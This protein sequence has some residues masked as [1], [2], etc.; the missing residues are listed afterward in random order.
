[1]QGTVLKSNVTLPASLQMPA[2]HVVRS[3][4][5]IRLSLLVAGVIAN[6]LVGMTQPLRAQLVAVQSAA[7]TQNRSDADAVAKRPNVVLIT[8]DDQP[9]SVLGCYGDPLA[10]T[11]NI[12]H[13]AAKGTRFTQSTVSHSICWVSRTS[14]LSGRYG[15][16]YSSPADPDALLP[17]YL[18]TMYPQ[19]LRD[20]GYRTGHFGK[21]GPRLPAGFQPQSLFDAFDPIGRDPFFHP[22]PDGSLRHETDLIVD[23]GIAFVSD[24]DS[25]A[26]FMLHLSFNACHGEDGDRRPGVGFYPWPQSADDL[27]VDT[28]FPPPMRNAQEHFDSLPD[29]IATAINRERFFWAW[30][31]P[32]KYQT[33]LRAYYRMTSGIDHALGRFLQSLEQ[34][35]ILENTILVYTSDNGDALGSRGLQGKWSHFDES[36]VVPLIIV[37]PRVA[38]ANRGQ[39]ADAQVVNVDLPSTILEWAGV[40]IPNSY[41]GRSLVPLVNSA[42]TPADWRTD[43]FHEHY[44]VRTRL[45]AFEGVR[46]DRYK[47]ARYV[48]HGNYEFLHDRHSDPL[49]LINL[50]ADPAYADVR[51]RLSDL[52]D[53]RVAELGGELRPL[54][55]AFQASSPRHPAIA[56]NVSAQQDDD[57]YTRMF[58]GKTLNQ[59]AGDSRYWSVQDGAITGKTDGSLDK[60]RFLTWTHSTVQ[61]FDLQMQ[62]RITPGGNSGIQYRGLSR[63]DIDLDIV[64]GYQCDIVADVPQYNGMLYEERGRRILAHTGEKVVIDP[65]GQPWIVDRLATDG[66]PSVTEAAGQWHDYRVLVRGNHHQH[67]INGHLTVDVIDLDAAGR[68]LEGVVAMQVHVGPAMTVQFRDLKIRQ[69]ADDLPLIAADEVTIPAGAI[70][71]R[72]QGQLPAD[73]QPPVYGD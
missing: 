69:L 67:W 54:T 70:G 64:S 44:A 1:M 21:W 3:L 73:W 55:A 7:V 53:Q 14:V 42:E 46:T 52:T 48:D 41:Q 2:A 13:L 16:S 71:V 37:D 17:E 34:R 51:Q 6:A 26:P 27:F 63:P 47:Y 35:G 57:G 9:S 68:S 45:A 43:S 72:P 59:W 12:D 10:H 15:R 28:V 58:D 38:T 61:N 18:P 4:V 11:P 65:V 33:N 29:F 31:T 60:N 49:E 30:N 24:D 56:A 36:L 5:A 19:R 20:A 66:L 40:Q 8:V 39:T 25:D 32:Q 50:A 23:R 22:Q 62:V